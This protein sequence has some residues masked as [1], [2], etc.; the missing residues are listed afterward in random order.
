MGQLPLQHTSRHD[1]GEETDVHP[2][3]TSRWCDEPTRLEAI[4]HCTHHNQLHLESERQAGLLLG[5]S[6]ST[7]PRRG[8]SCSSMVVHAR[9][10][11]VGA[12]IIGMDHLGTRP[13]K[14]AKLRTH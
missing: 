5:W 7:S 2:E 9:N 10:G 8:L 14:E 4:Q 11:S 12:G 1:T 6:G 3:K 13:L